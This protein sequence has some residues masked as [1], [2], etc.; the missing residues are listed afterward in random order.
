MNEESGGVE[1][2]M[3]LVDENPTAGLEK[4]EL[5][6]K[7]DQALEQL[8]ETHRSVIVMHEFEE[9]EYREI[10]QKMDCSIGTIM[11]RL[12]YA[13]KKLA[14]LLSKYKQEEGL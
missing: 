8:S 2:L 4:N 9:M 13:R 1:R 10:A 12:F 3:P 7:I 5:R 11:S 6:K 14:T